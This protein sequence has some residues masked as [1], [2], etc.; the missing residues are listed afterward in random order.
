MCPPTERSTNSKV[1][2]AEALK[3]AHP[4]MLVG[5]VGM[6]VEP[7]QAEEILQSGKADVVFLAR[8]MM[9]NPHWPIHAAKKLGAPVQRSVQ[10]DRGF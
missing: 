5:A 3:K 8:E 1:P 6:I 2:Y 9:R 10:Y 4:D 7:E